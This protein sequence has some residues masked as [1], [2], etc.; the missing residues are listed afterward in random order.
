MNT[1]LQTSSTLTFELSSETPW[2]SLYPILLSCVKRW[3]Y[4][5]NVFSWTGQESDIAWDIV[6]TAMRRTFEYALKAQNEGIEISS[7][8]RLSIVIAKN[9]FLDLRRKDR[10]LLH[11]D[12]DCYS[13]WDWPITYNEI[14]I[15]EA[16][17][18]KVHEQWL[19]QEIAKEIAN[20]PPKLRLAMLIDIAKRMEFDL[21]PT[22][23]QAAFLEVGIQLQDFKDL[24]PE[25]PIMRSRHSSLVSLGY[26]KLEMSFRTRESSEVV[27]STSRA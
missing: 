17:L 20:Y 7:L 19:F 24:L 13:Q 22:S 18:D 9:C 14:D 5:S 8:E 21:Q 4:N 12:C 25:D 6:L 2:A 10:R 23:L 27:L 1:C 3:V 11:F 15:A 26:R 16:V